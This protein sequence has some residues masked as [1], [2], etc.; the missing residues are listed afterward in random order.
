V[1][2]PAA[3]C[4]GAVASLAIAHARRPHTPAAEASR[5]LPGQESSTR[6]ATHLLGALP[7]DWQRDVARPCIHRTPERRCAMVGVGTRFRSAC[8]IRSPTSTAPTTEARRSTS[9]PSSTVRTQPASSAAA[10]AGSTTRWSTARARPGAPTAVRR[11]DS[12]YV[13]D[14]RSWQTDEP[15]LDMTGAAILAGAVQ[16]AAPRQGRA[17]RR[18]VPTGDRTTRRG[19]LELNPAAL[20]EGHQNG[21]MDFAADRSVTGPVPWVVGRCQYPIGQR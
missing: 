13:D 4:A 2:R 6:R 14:V 12:R 9:A 11:R 8:S 3:R 21:P 20:H 18:C 17:R 7:I 16:L 1:A 19:Q 10:S 15:A 5:Y